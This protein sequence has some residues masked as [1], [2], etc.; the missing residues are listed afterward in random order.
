MGHLH[1]GRY[2]IFVLVHL[3]SCAQLW[4]YCVT[5]TSFFVETP[6][7]ESLASTTKEFFVLMRNGYTR[8]HRVLYL[9]VR[10]ISPEEN[11]PP[12]RVRIWFRISVRIRAR[13]QF[14][15][16]A[17]FL[18]PIFIIIIVINNTI[19]IIVNVVSITIALA[20]NKTKPLG[21]IQETSYNQ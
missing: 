19:I 15:S 13:G 4:W 2:L 5:T 14:F 7:L 8:Y 20:H 12:V 6:S 9:G 3:H 16:G 21:N 10:K 17:I 1:L 11:C 18:E